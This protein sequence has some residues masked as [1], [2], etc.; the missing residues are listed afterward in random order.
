MKIL[1]CQSLQIVL[2]PK[3]KHQSPAVD[4]TLHLVKKRKP[5]SLF[6][7]TLYN[8]GF[9]MSW[10]TDTINAD[11]LFPS[12][13]KALSNFACLISSLGMTFLPEVL[14]VPYTHRLI[15]ICFIVDSI[16]L[17]FVVVTI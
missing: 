12:V 16:F 4:K 2:S 10:D 3:G 8:G 9:H 13:N 6:C 15:W 11:L 17:N 14:L 7:V 5:L 1:S